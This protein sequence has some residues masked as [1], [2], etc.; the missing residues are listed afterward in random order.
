[1]IQEFLITL[2]LEPNLLP[3]IL[4]DLGMFLHDL[5]PL[6]NQAPFCF[7]D[8]TF[9]VL[10]AWNISPKVFEWFVTSHHLGPYSSSTA[11]IPLSE[12]PTPLMSK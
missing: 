10:P 9:A 8:F 6:R 3:R 11:L 2:R 5:V 7:R 4:C 12:T 1:M